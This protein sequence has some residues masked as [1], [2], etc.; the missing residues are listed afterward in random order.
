MIEIGVKALYTIILFAVTL[1]CLREAWLVW[2]EHPLQIGQFVGTKD[3]ADAPSMADSF[4]RLVVQQQ[5]VLF[6]LYKGADSKPGEFRVSSGDVLTIHLADLVRMPGSSLDSLKIE[7]AGINVTSVLTTLRRWI[8]APNEITGSVDLIGTQVIVSANWTNP[9][10]TSDRRT[11]WQMLVLP[12]QATLQAASFDLACRILFARIP[13]DDVW[14]KDVSESDFCTFSTALFK[15][16]AYLTARSL[17]VNEAD[18]KAANELLQTAQRLIDRLVVDKSNLIFAYK[19]GGYIELEQVASSTNPD[20]NVIKRQLDKAQ[21]LLSDYMKQFAKHDPSASD[22]DVQEKLASLV[23]RGGAPQTA[24]N[25]GQVDASTFLQTVNSALKDTTSQ[26]ASNTPLVL[27]PGTS[28]GPAEGKTAGTFGCFVEK[29]GRKFLLSLAYIVGAVGDSVVS[30]ALI[31]VAAE[32][33]KIG[34]VADVDGAFALVTIESG[35][36]IRND[37]IKGVAPDPRLNSAVRLIGRNMGTSKAVITAVEVDGLR[38]E[39]EHG[40]LVLNG[41]VETN[42]IGLP[43]DG[44]G[45]VLDDA[46]QLIGLLAASSTTTSYVMVVKAFLDRKGLKLIQ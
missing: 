33:R 15:F 22:A 8:V 31:D 16:R 2:F 6:D 9:P 46:G 41:L 38:I 43:G 7:A 11:A 14:L 35:L 12:T 21:A 19:L 29:D 17:A 32:H 36:E 1:F 5:N 40:S 13:P 26:N 34:K 20:P 44:G 3:G 25:L 27:R 45:P 37:Q 23:T 24:E 4:R 18:T 30:P 10:H 39:T 28:I 42:R